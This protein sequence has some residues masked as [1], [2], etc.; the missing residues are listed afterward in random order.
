MGHSSEDIVE[1]LKQNSESARR[2]GYDGDAD[3]LERA[4]GTIVALRLRAER[5]EDIMRGAA[6]LI[7][8]E[9]QME[10]T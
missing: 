6:P 4:A 9:C 10:A 3:L 2:L 1:E 8:D 7:G 5:L